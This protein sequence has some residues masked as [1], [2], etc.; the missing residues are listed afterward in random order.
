M[1][2]NL[3]RVFGSVSFRI[4]FRAIGVTFSLAWPNEDP[5]RKLY[6]RGR[7]ISKV[8]E[9][10]D[11]KAQLSEKFLQEDNVPEIKRALEQLKQLVER[12]A[13]Q[14]KLCALGASFSLDDYA[15]KGWLALCSYN[16]K[17]A[18]QA[19]H[20]HVQWRVNVCDGRSVLPSDIP[21]QLRARKAF[22]QGC[23]SLGRPLLVV[24]GK[25]HTGKNKS[26]FLRLLAFCID[27]ALDIAPLDRNPGRKL[28][29]IVDLTDITWRN[30]DAV[31]LKALFDV[32]AHQY[33]GRLEVFW[34]VNAPRIFSGLWHVVKPA[35]ENG[36]RERVRFVTSRHSYCAELVEAHGRHVLPEVWSRCQKFSCLTA[37]LL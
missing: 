13:L 21:S 31:T 17:E 32:I 9:P 16:V 5:D 2:V 12:E 28:S 35:V 34:F 25:R 3:L 4:R 27:K 14:E 30:L 20:A 26:E 10:L 33:P 36:V 6:A 1:V 8:P 7:C 22:L 11:E 24:M 15:L 18:A 37:D 19:L 29:A 23:D